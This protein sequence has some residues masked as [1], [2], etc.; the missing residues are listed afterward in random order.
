DPANAGWASAKLQLREDQV[1]GAAAASGVSEVGGLGPRELP[2]LAW[3]CATQLYFDAT[4][5]RA[6]AAQANRL[7]SAEAEPLGAQGLSNLLWP[8]TRLRASGPQLFRAVGAAACDQMSGFSNQATSN[9]VWGPGTS[10]RLEV[11]LMGTACKAAQ[12]EAPGLT[13]QGIANL[14]RCSTSPQVKGIP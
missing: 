3:A 4:V 10:E 14:G 5:S 2:S 8:S 7:A 1:P 6:P 12:A 13:S 11:R 9:S